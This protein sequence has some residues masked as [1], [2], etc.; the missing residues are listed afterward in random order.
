LSYRLG[1]FGIIKALKMAMVSL[2][3]HKAIT[4]QNIIERLQTEPFVYLVSPSLYNGPSDNNGL[5]KVLG[6]HEKETKESD[7]MDLLI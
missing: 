5:V 6:F 4:S 7:K 2:K 3:N 1:Y